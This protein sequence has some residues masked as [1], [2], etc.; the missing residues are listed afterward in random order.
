MMS[1]DATRR[2]AAVAER[3]AARDRRAEERQRRDVWMRALRHASYYRP[4]T[5]IEQREMSAWLADA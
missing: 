5:L 3:Q 4:L 1:D 2:L